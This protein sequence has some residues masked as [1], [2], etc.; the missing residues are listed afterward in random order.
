[1]LPASASTKQPQREGRESGAGHGG[2]LRNK[3]PDM[4]T[5]PQLNTGGNYGALRK[6]PLL[7]RRL[8]I[9]IYTVSSYRGP[10]T[11]QRKIHVFHFGRHIPAMG[12]LLTCSMD[13]L[14]NSGEHQIYCTLWNYWKKSVMQQGSRIDKAGS[15]PDTPSSTVIWW[16][17]SKS[18]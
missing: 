14:L 2:K 17:S 13:S 10:R 9:Y 18:K 7:L 3:P 15:W 11:P 8:P 6:T 1:M 12:P 5:C 16:G 4:W